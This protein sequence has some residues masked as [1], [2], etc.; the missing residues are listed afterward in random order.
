MR[1]MTDEELERLFLR[2]G[3]ARRL[4]C[5]RW[6][7]VLRRLGIRCRSPVTFG[8]LDHVWFS[9]SFVLP[10]MATVGVA[11]WWL[12]LVPGRALVYIAAL[13]L[14]LNPMLTSLRYRRIRKRLQDVDSGVAP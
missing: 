5:P 8:F 11:V 6:G 12:G 13:S 7:R 14:I 3:I 10:F 2:A 9:A 1:D 4:V